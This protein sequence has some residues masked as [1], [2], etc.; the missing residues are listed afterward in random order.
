MRRTRPFL[1]ALLLSAVVL[2]GC[3]K[4]ASTSSGSAGQP[5]GTAAVGAQPSTTNGVPLDANGCPTSNAIGLAKTKFAVHAGLGFG[6]FHRYIYKPLKAGSFA[7]GANG[8]LAAF[9]KAGATA[10]FD[11]REI[12]LAAEDVKA[13]P[14]LCKVLA[15]PLRRLA[16]TLG[17]LG[18]K[19]KGGDTSAVD[20]ANSQIAAIGST[21]SM[22]GAPIADRTDENNG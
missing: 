16:D 8:R 9:V 19:I 2:S 7:K 15:A 1:L 21:S 6:T 5:G 4:K 12:R 20:D 22:G 13:N 14:T 10:L 18:S 11:K 3:G 17:G